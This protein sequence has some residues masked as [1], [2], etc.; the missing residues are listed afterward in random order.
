MTHRSSFLFVFAAFACG[1]MGEDD[2]PETLR[3][4]IALETLGREGFYCFGFS[5]PEFAGRTLRG[6]R[7]EPPEDPALQLH[8]AVLYALR[9]IS[10][11]EET[12][13]NGDPEFATGLH[14][15]TPGGEQFQLPPD[16]GLQ[17]PPDTVRF[18]IDAHALRLADGPPQSSKVILDF[19]DTPP[20]HMAARFTARAPVPTIEPH[21]TAKATGVCTAAAPMRAIGV[22]PHMHQAGTE[23][24]GDILHEGGE[25]ETAVHLTPWNWSEQLIHPLAL[26]IAAGDKIETNCFWENPTPNPIEKGT[27]TTQEMCEQTYIAWPAEAAKCE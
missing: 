5:R 2:G 4:E 11:D 12:K 24:R 15:W 21:A 8:H 25:R 22:W 10:D 13:C 9:N 1:C 14:V 27:L 20:L 7:V 26:D 6:V 16:V 3:F 23:F 17:V 18:A 19:Y